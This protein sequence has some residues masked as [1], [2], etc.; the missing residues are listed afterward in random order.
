MAITH[1]FLKALGIEED[2]AEEI[3]TAHLETVNAIKA[4]RDELKSKAE[5]IDT[6]TAER[7]QL[8]ADLQAAKEAGG[9]AAKVQADFDAYKAQVETEKTNVSKRKLIRTA[10]E[11]AG[12]N[13]AALDLMLNAV[14]LD[15][16]ELDGE[17][18]KDA[19]SVINPVKQTY[20]GLFGTTGT[21]GTKPVEPPTGG[22][23]VHGTGRAAAIAA[24]YQEAMYGAPKT[25][26]KE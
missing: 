5:S 14:P 6:L 15:T 11:K 26:G 7:D 1:K 13:P 3:L 22:R 23:T 2:K 9:N 17:N 20:A 4:E 25:G 21:Q 16:V 10:L 18:L 19:D 8:K 24:K 12:A